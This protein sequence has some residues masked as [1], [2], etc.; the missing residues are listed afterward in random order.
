MRLR[1]Q[2]FDLQAH[3]SLGTEKSMC[4]QSSLLLHLLLLWMMS[5]QLHNE[6]KAPPQALSLLIVTIAVTV[7]AASH[8]QAPTMCLDLFGGQ[9]K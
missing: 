4:P 1:I 7:I 5:G 6:R 2:T 8:R 9:L 3:R